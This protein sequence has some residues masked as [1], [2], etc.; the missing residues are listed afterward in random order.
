[1]VRTSPKVISLFSGCG[2]FDIG[3]KEAGFDIVF[4]TDNWEVATET[5]KKNKQKGQEIV[6]ADIGEIDF[7]KIKK[8]HKNNKENILKIEERLFLKD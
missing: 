7:R 2:G 3:F 5:L 1:M 8:N 6:C 4:S